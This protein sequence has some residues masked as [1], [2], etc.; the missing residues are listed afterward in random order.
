MRVAALFVRRDSHYKAMADVDC[1]DEDRD[2]LTWP[3]GCPGIFHPPCRTWGNLSQFVKS[4]PVYE[5]GLALWSMAMVRRYGG[6]LEHPITSK[7]WRE[8]GC[9]SPGFRDRHGG[10]FVTVNQADF[11]HRA[12]KAT[13]LYIVGAPVPQ[14]P[15]DLAG[16]SATVEGMGKAERERTP[17][18]FAALL[19]HI[20]RSVR[21]EAACV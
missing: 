2:A 17:E 5:R 7:L 3:G 4:A 1:Y 18:P 10:V 19:V 8:A 21:R 12:Q 13:G 20:A 11:G 15:F 6:V 14:L 9:L 16:C